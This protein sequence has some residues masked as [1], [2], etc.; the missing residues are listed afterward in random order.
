MDSQDI[1]N[2]V[3]GHLA[4]MDTQAAEAIKW[5]DALTSTSEIRLKQDSRLEFHNLF[6][7]IGYKVEYLRAGIK[8]IS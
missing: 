2:R 8:K 7:S 4:S 5:L 1:K 6:D 3:L